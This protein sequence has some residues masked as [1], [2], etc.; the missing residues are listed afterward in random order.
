MGN[1]CKPGKPPA[2]KG[3][4]KLKVDG[5]SGVPDGTPCDVTYKILLVGDCGIGKTSLILRWALGSFP[6]RLDSLNFDQKEKT[7]KLKGKVVRLQIWDTAGQERFRTIS[8]AYYRGAH[9]IVLAYD[10]SDEK[11][12]QNTTRQWLQEVDRYAGSTVAKMLLGLKTDQTRAVPIKDA[13]AKAEELGIVHMELSA[14]AGN[15]DE[16]NKPFIHIASQLLDEE[17]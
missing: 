7:F 10:V 15:D 13:E 5:Y 6:Q 12:F 8:S 16:I 17:P 3:P 4:S 11:S 14:M 9:G 1:Q 2:T